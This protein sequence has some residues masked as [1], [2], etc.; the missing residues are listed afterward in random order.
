[1]TLTELHI[2]WDNL[3]KSRRETAIRS[4]FDEL[5]RDPEQYEDFIY[6]I[7][8]QAVDLETDDYF[9]TEGLKV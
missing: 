7:L 2:E 4:L 3:S 9:G 8:S 5:Q 1:M 6:D